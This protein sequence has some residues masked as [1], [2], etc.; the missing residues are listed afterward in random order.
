MKNILIIAPEFLPIPCVE[1]GAIEQLIDNYLKHN[2]I[3][4]TYNIT[5]YS[6]YSKKI[7]SETIQEYKNT[8]FRYINFNTI[9]YHKNKL[10]YAILR[11]IFKKNIYP[12]AYCKCVIEN[13]IKN[14]EINKHDLIIVENQVESITTYNKL[15]NKKIIL[16]LHNDYLNT[17]TP[18]KEEIICALDELW[19][20]SNFICNRGKEINPNLK[21][22]TLYNG[23]NLKK[24]DLEKIDK[25]TQEEY[26]KQ[27]NIKKND[28]VIIYSGRIMPDKGVYELIK[29]FNIAK[30]KCKQL[31]LLIIGKKRD[32]SQYINNYC[33][34]IKKEA[35][36]NKNDIIF[37][38]YV[39]QKEIQYLYSLASMQVVPSLCNE[40]FGLIVVEGA[41]MEIPLIVTNVGG[42]PE[43]VDQNSAIIIEKENIVNNIA[44]AITQLYN[45]KEYSN[46]LVSNATKKIKKFDIKQYTKNFENCIKEYFKENG[47]KGE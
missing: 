38:G 6:P 3:K 9:N 42:I 45:N 34:L 1:G 30:E 35:E 23:V 21:T 4:K 40:A 44:N 47:D 14:K 24:F 37:K 5:V 28:I 15:L 39:E 25:K 16:H 17:Q 43:I 41:S 33:E 2:A 13:L 27:L 36:K 11:R 26:K 7:T 32:N 12:T 46:K 31:K 22:R 19:G 8:T 20:V 18:N 29:S 10:K